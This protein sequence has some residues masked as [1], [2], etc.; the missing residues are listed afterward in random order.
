VLGN[1]EILVNPNGGSVRIEHANIQWLLTPIP[2]TGVGVDELT[3]VDSTFVIPEGRPGIPGLPG[4]LFGDI[5]VGGCTTGQVTGNSLSGYRIGTNSCSVPISGNQINTAGFAM[6]I[7]SHTDLAL[8]DMD[9]PGANVFIGD[10]SGNQPVLQISG[11]TVLAGSTWT[12][13]QPGVVLMPYNIRAQGTVVIA[14]GSL[15][16]VGITGFISEAG[17]LVH[18]AGSAAA[19]VVATVINDDSI[20]GDSGANGIDASPPRFSINPTGE[21]LILAVGGSVRIEHADIRWIIFSLQASSIAEVWILDSSI[22]VPE[23]R[24]GQIFSPSFG[25]T[26]VDAPCTTGAITNN[27]FTRVNLYVDAGCVIPIA[28]NTFL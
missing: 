14:A 22:S 12:F 9:G 16:K 28:P 3:I 5:Y 6:N 26:R 25:A 21:T 19:P 11:A 17:G 7:S 13:D 1:G 24:P 10:G 8:V 23:R 18:L 2:Y 20:G 4:P 15:L 27:V